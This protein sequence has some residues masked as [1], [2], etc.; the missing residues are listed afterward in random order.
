MP[1]SSSGWVHCVPEEEKVH[2]LMEEGATFIVGT[3]V[4]FFMCLGLPG[5]C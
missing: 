1:E 4:S 2:F 3:P 5:K